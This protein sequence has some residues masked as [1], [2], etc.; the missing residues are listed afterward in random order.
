MVRHLVITLLFSALALP[1]FAA[2][3]QPVTLTISAEKEIVVVENGVPVTKRVPAE[4]AEPGA[5]LIYTLHYANTAEA[6]ATNVAFS[7][8]VP[9]LTVYIDGSASG[10]DATIDFSVDGGAS[11]APLAD[12]NVID[13]NT[14]NPRSATAA[15]VTTLRWHL[16]T[17]PPGGQGELSFKVRV[18]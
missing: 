1:A 12:L 3:E 2:G 10:S 6:P 9:A 17:I 11:F 8:P 14:G 4:A 5:E 7:D 15:D 16:K 13:K 18:K